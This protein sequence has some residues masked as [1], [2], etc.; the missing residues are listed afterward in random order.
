[1]NPLLG[2]DNPE[3][4]DTKL[5][6]MRYSVESYVRGR[7]EKGDVSHIS[8]YIRDLSKGTWV[9]T[10]EDENFAA[11]SLIKVPLMIAYLKMAEEDIILLSK[12][13]RYEK[14]WDLIP[15]NISPD[16]S[17]QLGNAYTIDQLLRYM[18]VYSDNIA[19][20]L[21]LENLDL[22]YLA[23]VFSDLQLT[24][25]DLEEGEYQISAKGYST[26][27]RVL[28]NATYLNAELSEKAIR[29]LTESEFRDGIVAGVPANL[30][31]A[32]KFAE[33]RYQT[34]NL[35]T[36]GVQLHDCGIVYYPQRPYLLC[37]MTKGRDMDV[38]KGVIKDISKIVYDHQGSAM[39]VL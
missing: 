24:T 7:K 29:L 3:G 35:V 11:A 33:R 32:H 23:K 25:P 22:K 9:G 30:T 5:E 36:E 4:G 38:L 37:V 31:I 12:Q 2:V 19:S 27:F 20:E 10:D 39:D 13:L 1:V 21:L 28:Y 17:A 34:K 18:I 6:G 14:E 15:Q 26:F 16:K 8:V